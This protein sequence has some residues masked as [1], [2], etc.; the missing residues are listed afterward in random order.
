MASKPT[1]IMSPRDQDLLVALERSPLTVRQ[2]L[3]L[4]VTFCYPFTTERRV[5]ERLQALCKA[6][7][8]RCFPYSTAGRGALSYY[9][10]SP[11]GYRL[12]HGPEAKLPTKNFCSPVGIA[13]QHHTFC[14]AEF[15]VHTAVGAH[16]AKVALSGFYRENTVQLTVGE[17]RLWPDCAFQLI[18]PLGG[19]FS[20]F[21]ELDNSSERISTTG[22][23]D[24]WER[25]ILLYD[26]LQARYA[27]RFRVLVIATKSAAR[28]RH[29]LEAAARL[30][31]NPHR[32]LFYGITLDDY[33]G[34]DHPL[35]ESFFRNHLGW[36]VALI[37]RLHHKPKATPQ[38]A[39]PVLASSTVPGRLSP[40]SVADSVTS[41]GSHRSPLSE[42]QALGT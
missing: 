32:S 1:V 25:K 11:L 21:V 17:D 26:A 42:P 36:K 31:Q 20:F 34:C 29:I 27:K 10:L 41:F 30:M 2:L 24:S 33:L 12:L 22:H 28:V 37:S 14:L 13:R 3:K 18:T 40:L 15:I 19:E 5:Q 39:A 9:T 7:W 8:L 4:S 16:A 38:F 23:S 35:H 6:G